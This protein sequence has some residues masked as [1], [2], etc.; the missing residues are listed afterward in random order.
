MCF[1]FSIRWIFA[2]TAIV[3]LALSALSVERIWISSI[4]IQLI[5]LVM[6]GMVAVMLGLSQWVRS[7]QR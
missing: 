6:P 2:A 3:G 4:V 7:L 5:F 1:Q